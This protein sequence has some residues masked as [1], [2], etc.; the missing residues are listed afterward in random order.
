MSVEINYNTEKALEEDF[1]QYLNIALS[2]GFSKGTANVSPADMKKL[3]GLLSHY[4]KK[5]HPFTACVRDNRKRFGPLTEKYCAVLKDLIEG[6]THWRN[7]KK[8]NLSEDTLM[9]LYALDLPDGFLHALSEWEPGE[10]L[11]ETEEELDLADVVWDK[12][13]GSRYL[14]EKINA[15]LNEDEENESNDSV[16]MY[17]VSDISGDKAL[18]SH[19]GSEYYVVPFSVDNSGDVSIAEEDEW[20]EVE[21]AWVNS[22]EA[23]LS[24]EGVIAEVYLSNGDA[25]EEREG[26]IW[27]TIAKEGTWKYSPGPGQKPIPRPLTFVKEGKSNTK[28]LVVSIEELKSNFYSGA[29]Q[30]VTVPLTHED[31]VLDNTGFIREMKIEEDED[32]KA[33][34][35]AGIEFTEPKVKEKV[36]RKSIADI[37]SGIH[38]DYVK[39]DTGN[40]YT[41]IVAHAALTN[42]PWLNG[43]KPFEINASENVEILAFSEE[44]SDDKSVSENNSLPPQGGDNVETVEESTSVEVSEPTFLSE[45]GIS[46]DEAKA[47]LAEYASLKTEQ[48]RGR[49]DERC[50]KWQEEGVSPALV[51]AA[52]SI[53]DADEGVAVI[54]LSEDGNDKTLTASDIVDRLIAAAPHVDLTEDKVK[55]SDV[56]GQ[57]PPADADGENSKAKLSLAERSLATQLMLEAAMSEEDAIAE[58]KRRLETNE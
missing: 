37:S 55:D 20:V 8:K 22:N 16:S 34:L 11:E 27:K 51:L 24:D 15:A 2:N 48:K 10:F 1:D 54:N 39:K 47:R 30:H 19:G 26:L 13:K 31:N 9:N 29:K 41:A 57:A 43:M 25:A 17:W 58:A 3:R 46:E 12:T 38:F 52:K 23:Y 56:E 53:L 33:L 21:E 42:N 49:I 18:V 6:N 40:K 7:Q 4:R 28:D 45:L 44:I 50:R 32:G 35:K 36:L 5:A 14:E